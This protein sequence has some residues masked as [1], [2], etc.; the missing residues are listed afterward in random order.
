MTMDLFRRRADFALSGLCAVI[1]AIVIAIEL[2]RF[3]APGLG[4]GLAIAMLVALV[5]SR[6]LLGDQPA[7]RYVVV[8]VM[9][10]QVV[11]MLIAARGHPL[12]IDLHMAFFAALAMC[13]LLY[14]I[15]TIVV[16]TAVVAVHHLGLGL[17]WSELVFYGAGGLERIAMHAVIL[18]AEAAALIWM[19]Y[20]TEAV[21]ALANAKGEEADEAAQ[22]AM[23]QTQTIAHNAERANVRGAQ[24]AL[25][26]RE[27]GQVVEAGIAGDFGKRITTQFEDE[28]LGQLA[29]NTNL[30]VER[31]EQGLA[32]TLV[33]LEA[34]S[35]ADLT[36]RVEGA[37]SGVF[38]RLKDDINGVAD[39]LG[40]VI[41]QLRQ[42]SGALKDATS[43]IL[44]GTNDLASR[45][46]KQAA[47]IEQTSAAMQHLAG[48]V[49]QN[50]QRA[51]DASATAAA[52]SRTA[53]EG[54][55]V[56]QQATIAMERLTETSR[57]IST[58][59]A[60]IDDIAFQTNLLALNASVEA[61]RAGDAGKGFAVVAVEVRRLAHSA[62]SASSDIKQLIERSSDEVRG[63]SQL[64]LDAARK[65]EAMLIAARSSSELMH[66]IARDSR[67]QASAI[68]EVNVAVRR[69]DE[70]TQHNAA[71]VQQTNAAI[72]QTE[73]QAGE[74][75]RI[76][77]VFRLEPQT[78]APRPG[79]ND[80]RARQ[81]RLAAAASSLKPH[82]K[83][84]L[85]KDWP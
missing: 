22:A 14:D 50:A 68:E 8:T 53:D 59:T 18:V 15:R 80:G 75:D 83:V 1:A 67:E 69:M 31:V 32:A 72:E 63:G 40:E 61:A 47:S 21:L 78:S 82:G 29:R 48:M 76:V 26:Q 5:L 13:A 38:T 66:N 44:G 41:G 71:L 65:L 55:Q 30:L 10:A 28:D 52:V 70:M 3:G 64:V 57:K 7:H 35:R 60:L 56:M 79:S 23:A 45:T 25:L 6:V 19:T 37:F 74:L 49:M 46:S 73:A 81:K 43:E 17:L 36:Q 12:Q 34:L 51:N 24:M 20:N 2:L 84:G 27:Y 4:V 42:T 11:A 39:K 77:D 9:M 54:G 58:I 16:A 85:A 33:V 62:A